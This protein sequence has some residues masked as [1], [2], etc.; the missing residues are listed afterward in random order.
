MAAARYAIFMVKPTVYVESTI[1]SFY[2]EERTLPDI[3]ARRQWTREWWDS[4]GE[5]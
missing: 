1:P 3:V 5:L 2:H 4:A